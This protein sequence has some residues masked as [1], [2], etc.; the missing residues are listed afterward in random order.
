M[1]WRKA[2]GKKN[3]IVNLMRGEVKEG[4]EEQ[5]EG[6]L[7]QRPLAAQK[8]N[9]STNK[10]RWEGG[11]TFQMELGGGLQPDHGGFADQLKEACL[12]PNSRRKPL[13]YLRG[14]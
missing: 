2:R 11:T 8:Q 13:K 12:C 6:K 1:L 7:A 14:Q 9:S 10:T 4:K 5:A 3:S